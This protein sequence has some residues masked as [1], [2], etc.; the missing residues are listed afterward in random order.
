MY[1]FMANMVSSRLSG[2]EKGSRTDQCSIAGY[3]AAS[4]FKVFNTALPFTFHFVTSTA[5]G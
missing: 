2:A 5:E 3:L 4:A 1:R